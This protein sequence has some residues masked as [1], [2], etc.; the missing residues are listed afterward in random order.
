MDEEEEGGIQLPV[1]PSEVSLPQPV[2]SPNLRSSQAAID[3]T[4]GSFYGRRDFENR[5]DADDLTPSTDRN[6]MRQ[7]SMVGAVLERIKSRKLPTAVDSDTDI[8]Y[9]DEEGEEDCD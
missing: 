8:D 1:E 6:I 2:V 4:F 5:Q 9:D 7:P 3:A